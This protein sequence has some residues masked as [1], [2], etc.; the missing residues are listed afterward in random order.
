MRTIVRQAIKNLLQVIPESRI[1]K[2]YD[3]AIAN[4][5]NGIFSNINSNVYQSIVT[6]IRISAGTTLELAVRNFLKTNN[7]IKVYYKAEIQKRYP[8]IKGLDFIITKGN[9]MWLVEQKT[10]AVHDTLKSKAINSMLMRARQA[11]ERLYGNY[12]IIP[13]VLVF[14]DKTESEIRD[15]LKN[16]I[17]LNFLVCNAVDFANTLGMELNR[18][19]MLEVKNSVIKNKFMQYIDYMMANSEMYSEIDAYFLYNRFMEDFSK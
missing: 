1:A 2:F 17:N 7:K 6:S 18:E 13:T 14:D 12:N 5:L 19:E 11:A 15:G 3:K 10:S 4:A 9:N 16:E 8:G